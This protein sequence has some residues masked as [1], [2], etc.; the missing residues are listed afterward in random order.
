MQNLFKKNY[1]FGILQSIQCQK[2]LNVSSS[3]GE[4]GR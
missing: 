2:L 3:K 1:I 4:N